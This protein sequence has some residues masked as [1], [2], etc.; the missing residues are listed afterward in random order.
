MRYLL[1]GKAIARSGALR[2]RSLAGATL[3]FYRFDEADAASRFPRWGWSPAAEAELAGEEVGRAAVRADGCFE[4]ALD[5]YSGGGLRV[6]LAA[7]RRSRAAAAG[8]SAFG[9]LGHFQPVWRTRRNVP[10][11][12]VTIDL[13]ETAARELSRELELP[14]VADRVGRD[15][16]G[17]PGSLSRL[18]PRSQAGSCRRVGFAPGWPNEVPE[19]RPPAAAAEVA[20]APA[21]PLPREV[22]PASLRAE[23]RKLA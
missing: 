22:P 2:A 10:S 18:S 12:T 11:A 19:G 6:A 9:L 3:I 14:R 15:A 5:A 8:K 16:Y 13:N 7:A 20:F 23:K 17:E 4:V 21:W 1:S